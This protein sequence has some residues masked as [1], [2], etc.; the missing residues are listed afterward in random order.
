MRAV[1]IH[2]TVEFVVEVLVVLV[3]LLLLHLFELIP[4]LSLLLLLGTPRDPVFFFGP[5]A[6]MRLQ[7]VV[8]FFVL[9]LLL[10]EPWNSR[11]F[12]GLL[13][14]IIIRFL[15]EPWNRIFL[16]L[17]LLLGQPRNASTRLAFLILLAVLLL[18][19]HPVDALGRWLLLILPRLLPAV[20]VLREPR[21]AAGLFSW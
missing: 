14:G 19:G 9:R 15:G 8:I 20:I 2:A 17:F 12:R 21:N 4:L 5:V 13:L 3:F 7:P 10:R 16:L 11:L 1:K 6:A 18:P